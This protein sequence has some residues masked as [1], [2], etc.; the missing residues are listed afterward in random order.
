MK[1]QKVLDRIEY[2]SDCH[3]CYTEEEVLSAMKKYAKQKCKEQV[4]LLSEFL[5]EDLK[6]KDKMPVPSFD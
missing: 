6:G 3:H 1:A 2:K 5:K 4:D